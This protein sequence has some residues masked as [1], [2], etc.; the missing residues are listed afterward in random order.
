MSLFD[1]SG[2]F[3]FLS[4]AI[5]KA[6]V[7]TQGF[8][9]CAAYTGLLQEHFHVGIPFQNPSHISQLSILPIQ[10]AVPRCIAWRHFSSSSLNACLHRLLSD[11]E[12]MRRENENAT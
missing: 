6:T 3:R 5:A 9:D 2:T 1:G 10:E 11:S 4:H 8:S 12:I 7:W